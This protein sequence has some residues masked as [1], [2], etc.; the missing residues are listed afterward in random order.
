MLTTIVIGL[1]S[2][3]ISAKGW[4]AAVEILAETNEVQPDEVLETMVDESDVGTG[5]GEIDEVELDEVQEVQQAQPKANQWYPGYFGAYSLD[6]GE[7]NIAI[8][9]SLSYGITDNFEIGS[10]LLLSAFGIFNATMKLSFAVIETQYAPVQMGLT[11]HQIYEPTRSIMGFD[12]LKEGDILP[13]TSKDPYYLESML[14]PAITAP[15]SR[16]VFLTIE[17][18]F[19]WRSFLYYQPEE[20]QQQDLWLR[21]LTPAFG[22]PVFAHPQPP[23]PPAIYRY[24]TLVSSLWIAGDLFLAPH[25][26]VRGLAIVPVMK[27]ADHNS[28]GPT[29]DLQISYQFKP[30][31]HLAHNPTLVLM[32]RK[33]YVPSSVTIQGGV[34]MKLPYRDD[35]FVPEFMPIISVTWTLSRHSPATEI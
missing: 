2:G 4:S 25:I 22:I 35:T 7:F 29:Q 11:L 12:Y 28:R 15:L 18:N 34:G 19:H 9:G 6:R 10:W 24:H 31:Q 21:Q 16:H 13:S 30:S 33:S 17:G 32:A 5:K 8:V 27:V 20:T 23:S 1:V 14:R 26:S 3:L